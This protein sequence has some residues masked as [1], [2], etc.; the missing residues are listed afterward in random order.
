MFYRKNFF[1][2]VELLIVLC[3]IGVAATLTG[4]KTYAMYKEQRFLS[5]SQQILHQLAM[6]QDLMLILD[7]DVEVKL[8]KDPQQQ[9]VSKI[10]VEKPLPKAWK[11]LIEK[12]LILTA[13]DTYQFE[14]STNQP[15]TLHFSLGQ[16]SQGFLYVKSSSN[17]KKAI[18][19]AGYPK[20]LTTLHSGSDEGLRSSQPAINTLLYPVEVYETRQ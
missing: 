18:Y 2:L 14:Q 10:F 4:I 8:L 9:V 5:E 17:Q 20:P 15:L 16:M 1:T 3:L 7:T 13:I 11:K 6:A 12:P 19:L